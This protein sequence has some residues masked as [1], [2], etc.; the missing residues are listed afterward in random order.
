MGK[1]IMSRREREQAHIFRKLQR[2]ELSRGMAAK[3]LNITVR[4]LT[5]KFSRFMR[6]GDA[7]LIHRGRGKQSE[8]RWCLAEEKK[9]I[10]LLRGEFSD[11]GP[12]FAAEKL[13]ELH[14]IAVSKE[15][16]RQAMIRN[17]LWKAKR[18]RVRHRKMCLNFVELAARPKK[19]IGSTVRSNKVYKPAANHP[20]RTYNAR[21]TVITPYSP[22]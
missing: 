7:G 12:T 17:G 9:A 1:L 6:E 15:T 22:A 2:G 4:W 3:A 11:F 10:E 18:A 5:K 19:V 14:G 8:K 20:W 13:S 16:L 21:S